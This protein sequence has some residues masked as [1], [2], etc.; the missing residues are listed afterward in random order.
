MEN[1]RTQY[2]DG[3]MSAGNGIPFDEN[4]SQAWKDGWSDSSEAMYGDD[5]L[6]IDTL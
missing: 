1:Y 6:D 3:Y 5:D 2:L 4:K